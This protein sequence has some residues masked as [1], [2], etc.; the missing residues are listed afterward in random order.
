MDKK[1]NAPSLAEAVSKEMRA[2]KKIFTTL[3][4]MA[5]VSSKT[6]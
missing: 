1:I 3:S 2:Q 6:V 4:V 5:W